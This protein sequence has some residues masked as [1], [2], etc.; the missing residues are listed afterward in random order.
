MTSLAI[1]PMNIDC[2]LKYTL[3]QTRITQ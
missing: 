2:K 1:K 3:R